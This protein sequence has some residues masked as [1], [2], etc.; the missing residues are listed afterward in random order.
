MQKLALIIRYLK[1]LSR[2]KTKYAV[3]PP[4][5]FRLITEV[6]ED[7]TLF[8]DYR[9]IEQL[10][11]EQL[12]NHTMVHVH[13]LGAGSSIHP[14]LERSISS[15]AKNSSKSKKQGRLLYRLSR[16]FKPATILELGTSLGYSTMYLAYGAPDAKVLSMEGCPNISKLAQQNFNRLNLNRIQLIQGHFDDTLTSTLKTLN[17]LDMV[18]IDGNHQKGPTLNY[19]EKCL[20][21]AGNDTCFIFDDIHWSEGM[22]EAWHEIINTKAV[23]LSVDFFFMGIIFIR[24]ELSKQHFDIRF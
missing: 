22:E 9:L 12:K 15:I 5:L 7:K 20:E 4:F 17:Q 8:A 13:D 11:Q 6:F 24:K 21:K 10:K 2:S 1:F 3:H 18:F 23:S 19:F 16:Y 14:T